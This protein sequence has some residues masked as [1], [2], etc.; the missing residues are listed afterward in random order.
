VS[1][2]IPICVYIYMCVYIYVY[3]C[4]YMCIYIYM[5]VPSC[6]SVIVLL[7]YVIK[8]GEVHRTSQCSHPEH[9]PAITGRIC[10]SDV[11][12]IHSGGGDSGVGPARRPH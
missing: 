3:M 9:R 5:I 10:T 2:S 4:V 1:A 11:H 6:V 8:G 12:T 7:H